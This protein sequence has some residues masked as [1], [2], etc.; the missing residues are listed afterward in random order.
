MVCEHAIKGIP[1]LGDIYVM[2]DG[3]VAPFSSNDSNGEWAKFRALHPS[4][5]FHMVALDK[6]ADKETMSKAK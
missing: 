3:D 5:K 6:S 2:C 1:N 4:I